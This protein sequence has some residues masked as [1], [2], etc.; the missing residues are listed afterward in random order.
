MCL[1]NGLSQCACMRGVLP[2][3]EPTAVCGW[4]GIRSVGGACCSLT[5]ALAFPLNWAQWRGIKSEGRPCGWGWADVVI[6]PS[7]GFSFSITI[8][9]RLP[10]V[11]RLGQQPGCDWS[12][13]F[14]TITGWYCN[15][16]VVTQCYINVSDECL[17]LFTFGCLAA[18]LRFVQFK[19]F[20]C[21]ACER[22]CRPIRAFAFR[23]R[24]GLLPSA[25]QEMWRGDW[26]ITT[27]TENKGI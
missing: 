9:I 19:L 24:N 3:G 7:L 26:C 10:E 11:G 13:L 5:C 16:I 6:C 8:W 22:N 12:S 21:Y 4:R 23:I 14:A 18:Y 20:V 15:N 25:S 17:A 27:K 1:D 2:G